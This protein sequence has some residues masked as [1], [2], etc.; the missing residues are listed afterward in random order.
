MATSQK[1]TFIVYLRAL[2]ACL[3]TNCHYEV[4]YPLKIF[5][6]GGLLGDVLFFAVS[7]LTL[8]IYLVQFPI[9]R[10]FNTHTRFPVN[11]ALCTVSILAAAF[12]LHCLCSFIMKSVPR[13]VR[14]LKIQEKL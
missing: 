10:F 14:R 3:I 12:L 1:I 13:A 5:A 6:N 8:E 11:F 2:A 4:I 9:I 7:G